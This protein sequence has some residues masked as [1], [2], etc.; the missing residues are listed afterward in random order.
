[1]EVFSHNPQFPLKLLSQTI[2]SQVNGPHFPPLPAEPAEPRDSLLPALR[3]VPDPGAAPAGIV[4]S[5]SVC[6]VHTHAHMQ[7]RRSAWKAGRVVTADLWGI[8][9]ELPQHGLDTVLRGQC[10]FPSVLQGRAGE[11]P[12]APPAPKVQLLTTKV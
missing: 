1:M 6:A 7:C 10:L 12:P 3:A 11:L 9:T 2:Q 8:G 4:C 5:V